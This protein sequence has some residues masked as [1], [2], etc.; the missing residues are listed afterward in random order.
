MVKKLRIVLDTNIIVSAII[1]KGKP[2]DIY[3]F[4]LNEKYT[5]ITS[6]TLISELTGILIKRFSLS[7]AEINLI[8]HQIREIFEVVH[9]KESINKVRDVDDNRVLEAAVEGKCHYI[10]TGDKDLLDLKSYNQ[11]TIL[12]PREFLEILGTKENG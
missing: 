3:D 2:R 1:F 5:T 10:I 8:E 6:S 4:A 9:P 12:T 11:I 7:L